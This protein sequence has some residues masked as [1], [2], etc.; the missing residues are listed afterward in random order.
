MLKGSSIKDVR[1]RGKGSANAYAC[2]KFACKRPKKWQN[3]ADVL[4]GWPLKGR[5]MLAT[6]NFLQ[7]E[8][9]CSLRQSYHIF[10]LENTANYSA[11]E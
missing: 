10:N 5:G 6:R 7:I 9:Y 2:V 11:R 3:F 4:N 8:K 1:A